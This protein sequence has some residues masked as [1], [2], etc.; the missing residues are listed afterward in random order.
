MA[1][2]M[3]EEQDIINAI[4]L[5]QADR[6]NIA[7]ESVEV[8]L[9]YD[10]DEGFFANVYVNRME[11]HMNTFEM[12]QALRMWIEQQLHQDPYA[13]GIKLILDDELG[14]VAALL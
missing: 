6:Q 3:I 4:C 8:E 10:D 5:Y 12:T 11:I 9:C 14:I 1:E 7:P 2:L 13:A